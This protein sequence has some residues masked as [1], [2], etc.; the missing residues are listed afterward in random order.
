MQSE[1]QPQFIATAPY[2]VVQDLI[3]SVQYY[4]QVLGFDIPRLW[5]DPPEFAMPSRD[6]FIVMLKQADPG[7][8]V[9]T[10]RDQSGFWDAYVWVSNVDALFAEY[11]DNGATVD[12]PPTIRDEYSM[13][14]F[15]ILDPD[16]YV[17][18][19]AENHPA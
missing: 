2:F 16:G 17:I 12:Y 18:A 6:G 3:R 4:H 14:E 8:S 15:A 9:T 19:F 11:K 7:V 5:G 10:N 1:N 13:R